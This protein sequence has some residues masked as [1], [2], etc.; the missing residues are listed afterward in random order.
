MGDI[1]N[2][3]GLPLDLCVCE[4][5]AK[6]KQK[7]VVKTVKRRYGKMMTV[8]EGI[9]EKN[10]DAKSLTKKLKS[11]MACGGTLKHGVI[12]LQGDHKEKVIAALTKCGF[13]E[14]SVEVR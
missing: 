9:D 6:E 8:I 3:C 12:E 10:I 2:V 13:S 14:D 7:I 5:I 4:D 11:M 1:C